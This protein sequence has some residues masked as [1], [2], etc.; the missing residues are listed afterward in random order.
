MASETTDKSFFLIH[1]FNS[2]FSPPAL[3]KS[4]KWLNLVAVNLVVVG[5]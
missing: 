2:V 3:F 5:W 1:K 4:Y